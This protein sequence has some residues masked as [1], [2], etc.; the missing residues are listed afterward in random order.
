MFCV[1]VFYVVFPYVC[2]CHI[3]KD[4]LLTYL[5]VMQFARYSHSIQTQIL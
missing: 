3:H 5:H 2:V 4:Y 1:C